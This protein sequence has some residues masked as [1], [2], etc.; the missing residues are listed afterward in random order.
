MKKMYL[1]ALVIMLVL[2]TAILW[3]GGEKESG[4]AK[5]AAKEKIVLQFWFPS[6]GKLNDDGTDI[7]TAS[8]ISAAVNSVGTDWN[9]YTLEDNI[10]NFDSGINV[11]WLDIKLAGGT[12]SVRNLSVSVE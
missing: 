3:S 11:I 5:E 1:I 10:S 7:T 2:P 8:V 6:G 12:T 9:T 4:A